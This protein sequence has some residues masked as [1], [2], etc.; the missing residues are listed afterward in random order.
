MSTYHKENIDSE[1]FRFF[2]EHVTKIPSKSQIEIYLKL[3]ET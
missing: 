1:P 2:Y 3:Y